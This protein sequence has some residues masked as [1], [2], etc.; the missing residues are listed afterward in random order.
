MEDE[1]APCAG[2]AARPRV[3]AQ[4]R[5]ARDSVAGQCLGSMA[6]GKR[7]KLLEDDGTWRCF[8]VA[9]EKK[10]DWYTAEDIVEA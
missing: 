7:G 5:L 9:C 3:G 4:V 8:L 1:G 10:R 6:E 2:A